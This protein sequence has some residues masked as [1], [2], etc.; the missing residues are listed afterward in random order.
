M[1]CVICDYS[2]LSQSE[3]NTSLPDI[4]QAPKKLIPSKNGIDH[5]CESCYNE[6]ID[7]QLDLMNE[8]EQGDLFAFKNFAQAR[9]SEL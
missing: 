2:P 1:R 5:Y 9:T 4:Y 6:I 7:S 8:D 3:F